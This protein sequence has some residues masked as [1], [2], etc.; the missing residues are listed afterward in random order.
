M[1]VHVDEILVHSKE[2]VAIETFA[3]ELGKKMKGKDMGGAKYYIGCMITRNRK[4]LE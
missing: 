3:A 4:T 1:A 2:Q